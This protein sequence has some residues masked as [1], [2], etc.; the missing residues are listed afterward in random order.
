ME[1]VLSKEEH[2]SASCP[3]LLPAR[4]LNEFTYCARLGYLE[5]VQ[6]QFA[7]NL[8]TEEGRFSHRR[9]D[10]NDGQLPEP[11]DEQA[12]K[13]SRSVLLSAYR[14]QLIAKI[15]L[16]ETDGRSATPVDYKR[17]KKPDI[18][19]GAYEP[20]RVQLHQVSINEWDRVLEIFSDCM[21]TV[22]EVGPNPYK[23]F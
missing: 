23:E 19:E 4:M 20:E 8:Y 17:G 5:W 21:D 7:D 12:P 3:D 6:G 10:Q 11:Q 2:K 1:A 22:E 14:A 9:V 18:P 15:D 13:V 16:V